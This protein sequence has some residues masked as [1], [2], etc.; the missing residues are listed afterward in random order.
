VLCLQDT[1]MLLLLLL[2]LLR[3]SFPTLSMTLN[4]CSSFSRLC[5]GN[6]VS[7]SCSRSVECEVQCP[8]Q[9]PFWHVELGPAFGIVYTAGADW[10]VP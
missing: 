8:E 7:G 10:L 6:P 3:N 9:Q 4:T 5:S 1:A 2:L